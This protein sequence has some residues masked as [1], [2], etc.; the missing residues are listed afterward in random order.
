MSRIHAGLSKF[1]ELLNKINELIEHRIEA[2]L[3]TISKTLLVGVRADRTY[4]LEQFVQMQEKMT[5]DRIQ[6]RLGFRV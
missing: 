3:K 6:V 2:N 5:K 1:E 4:T